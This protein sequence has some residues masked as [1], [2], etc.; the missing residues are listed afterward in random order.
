[1]VFRAKSQLKRQKRVLLQQQL[2]HVS[3]LLIR[4]L[5]ARKV[6]KYAQSIEETQ[7]RRFWD[8]YTVPS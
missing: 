5:I 6:L 3:T 7:I 8:I 1:M 4:V 2:V